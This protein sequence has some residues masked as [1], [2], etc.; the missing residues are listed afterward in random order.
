MPLQW[1]VKVTSPCVK[2]CKWSADGIGEP[3]GL[4]EQT[5]T[6]GVHVD[7][8]QQNQP[9]GNKNNYTHMKFITELLTSVY[10]TFAG[11][12]SFAGS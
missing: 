1:Q 5:T 3:C 10:K 4:T 11:M 7:K 2:G 8:L 9:L 6:H 12:D